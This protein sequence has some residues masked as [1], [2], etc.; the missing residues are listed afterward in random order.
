M[1]AKVPIYVQEPIRVKE[2]GPSV[3][4][5]L[6]KKYAEKKGIVGKDLRLELFETEECNEYKQNKEVKL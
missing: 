4:I 3:I 1:E 2:E 5:R 6:D